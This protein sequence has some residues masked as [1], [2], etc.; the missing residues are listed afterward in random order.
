MNNKIIQSLWI[1]KS[2]SVLERLSMTSFLANGHEYHLYSYDDLDGVPQGVQIKDANTVLDKNKIFAYRKTGGLGGFS[3]WFRYELLYC[4]GGY[5]MDLDMVCLKH[6]D[7]TD[8]YVFGWEAD[9]SLINACVLRFPVGDVCLE[10]LLKMCRDINTWISFERTRKNLFRIV[11]RITIGNK[12]QY[13]YPGETGPVGLTR[14]VK[15]C[16][17]QDK[18]KPPDFF[19]PVPWNSW[20]SIFDNTYRDGADFLEESYAIHL[21]NERL[22]RNGID[23]DGEFP[24]DSLYEQ[25]KRMYL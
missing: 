21:E 8:P 11:R 13:L 12:R 7:L 16:G 14:A 23:K 1:G 24:N 17:L 25:L 2:I 15:Y 19:Y 5:W 9:L 20:Q 18:A 4:Q 10:W 3:N 22:R 6:L